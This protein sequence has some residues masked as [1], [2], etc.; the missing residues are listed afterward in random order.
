MQ[1][2]LLDVD[3]PSV[4]DIAACFQRSGWALDRARFRNGDARAAAN[5]CYDD[6]PT[7][8][9]PDRDG[10]LQHVLARCGPAFVERVRQLLIGPD[11]P[12]RLLIGGLHLAGFIGTPELEDAIATAWRQTRLRED[13]LPAFIWAGAQCAGT[14]INEV[15][16]PIMDF[17]AALP[18]RPDQ[19]TT[20]GCYRDV[21]YYEGTRW[22]FARRLP[23]EALR[24]F[25]RC[26]ESGLLRHEITML[27]EEVDH[28]E[29]VQFIAQQMANLSRSIEGKKVVSPWLDLATR[30]YRSPKYSLS[31][32]SLGALQQLWAPVTTDAHLRRRAFQ[33]WSICAAKQHLALLRSIRRDDLLY[34][35]ALRVRIELGDPAAVAEF[36]VKLRTAS[37]RSYWWQFTRTHW[38][39][40]YLADLE[41]EFARRSVNVSADRPDFETDWVTAELVIKLDPAVATSILEKHWQHLRL[42]NSFIAVALYVATPRCVELVV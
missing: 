18:E 24:Y 3:D 28:P 32:A 31:E 21:V 14:K 35:E 2:V 36:R 38:L 27:L 10:L 39:D 41:E 26:S 20:Q 9:S 42:A 29:A 30:R 5:Y 11:L 25:I 15:L 12:R 40:D 33:L 6:R 34:D 17:W 7:Y 23:V 13:A 8:S 19:R 22:A 37:H 16:D 1:L 4:L